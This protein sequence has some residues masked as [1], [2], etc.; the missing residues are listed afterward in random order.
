M[1]NYLS[2]S[3]LTIFTIVVVIIIRFL[4]KNDSVADE[5]KK[6]ISRL[7]TPTK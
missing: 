3:L 7:L 1:Q 4:I 5:G 2:I 6:N